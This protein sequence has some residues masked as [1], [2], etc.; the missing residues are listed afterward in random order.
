LPVSRHNRFYTTDLFYDP[1]IYPQGLV[2]RIDFDKLFGWN[3]AGEPVS[4]S[5]EGKTPPPAPA[6]HPRFSS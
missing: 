1:S 3:S 5:K 4:Y 6:K 2:E